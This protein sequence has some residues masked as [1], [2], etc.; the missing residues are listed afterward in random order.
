MW[1]KTQAEQSKR[2]GLTG[3][4]KSDKEKKEERRERNAGCKNSGSSGD[5]SSLELTAVYLLLFPC[6]P[7]P[8]LKTAHTTGL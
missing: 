6:L 8:V 7:L 3:T 4:A 2:P 5:G 1:P